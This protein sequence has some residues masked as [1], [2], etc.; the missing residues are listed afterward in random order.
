MLCELSPSTKVLRRPNGF[1]CRTRVRTI[2][3]ID[4]YAKKKNDSSENAATTKYNYD[5]S[6]RPPKHHHSARRPTG[7]RTE[8]V[9][10]ART[11]TITPNSPATRNS[12]LSR[13]SRA[14]T[15]A[16]TV[17][18]RTKSSR[19]ATNGRTWTHVK[20]AHFRALFEYYDESG[21]RK[22]FVRIKKHKHQNEYWKVEKENI[23]W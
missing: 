10:A 13:K 23:K 2:I 17:V 11:H 12:S 6:D 7:K 9:S 19:G 3:I 16:A 8:L 15:C 18:G 5:D 14:H 22:K 20:R 4:V 1:R 21:E